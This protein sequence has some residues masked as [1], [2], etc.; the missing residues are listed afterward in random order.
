MNVASGHLDHIV[1]IWDMKSGN[2]VKELSGIHS[3]QITS[4]NITSGN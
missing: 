2:C 3:A 1:R 4:L